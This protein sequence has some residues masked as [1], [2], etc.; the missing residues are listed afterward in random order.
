MPEP[1]V[2]PLDWHAGI[3]AW[4]IESAP[5]VLDPL[6]LFTRWYCGV[7]HLR[8]MP[9]VRPAHRHYPEA[10]YELMCFTID[11]DSGVSIDTYDERTRTGTADNAEAL[12]PADIVYQ[13]HGTNDKQAEA[14]GAAFVRAIVHGALSPSRPPSGQSGTMVFAPGPARAFDVEWRRRLDATVEHYVTGHSMPD[15][16]A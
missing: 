3:G 11:P 15:G 16:R 4:F 9:G 2:G 13:W 6:G 5:D 14:V 8:D 10:T 12:Q 7:V 1:G